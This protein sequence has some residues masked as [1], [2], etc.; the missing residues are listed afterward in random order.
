MKVRCKRVSLSNDEM[1]AF[2]PKFKKNQT[3]ELTFGAEYDVLGLMF[4]FNA[5]ARGTGGYVVVAPAGDRVTIAP[6]LLFEVLE[7]R[8]PSNWQLRTSLEEIE[9]LP[10]ELSERY[11]FHDL[12]EREPGALGALRRA[13]RQE[14]S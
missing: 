10:E 4:T 11:F 9:L 8:I 6:L 12:S 3:F 1:P 13:L 2:G 5:P 7:P 14:H